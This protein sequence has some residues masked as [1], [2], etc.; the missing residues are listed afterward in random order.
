MNDGSEFPLLV[1]AGIAGLIVLQVSS[2]GGIAILI[3]I[4]A[5]VIA[6]AKDSK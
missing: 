4:C 1:G 6:L 5:F 2:L 3:G